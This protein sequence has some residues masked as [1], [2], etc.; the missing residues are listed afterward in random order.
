MP[1]KSDT[2]RKLEDG[3][4]Y[5]LFPMFNNLIVILNPND[6]Y[7]SNTLFSNPVIAY[8]ATHNF[9]FLFLVVGIDIDGEVES[10]EGK[11]KYYTLLL[12]CYYNIT[13]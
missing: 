2:A 8:G 11:K 5:F 1:K 7:F 4:L 10:A 9:L 12:H 6:R 3:E 13:F